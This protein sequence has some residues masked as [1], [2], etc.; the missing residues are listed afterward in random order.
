MGQSTG[1]K[2]KKSEAERLP[3][4]GP[5]HTCCC[6][7][8]LHRPPDRVARLPG[9]RGAAPISHRDLSPRL[10]KDRPT[11]GLT[12]RHRELS[13]TFPMSAW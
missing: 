4:H 5:R 12:Y 8:L 10:R 6:Q 2:R 11:L 9:A 3:E 1:K 13:R 7:V